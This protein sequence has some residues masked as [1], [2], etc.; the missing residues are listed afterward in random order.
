MLSTYAENIDE[1][2][3]TNKG[4][5]VIEGKWHGNVD[6][7]HE[8][9]KAVAFLTNLTIGKHKFAPQKI[10]E[11]EETVLVAIVNSAQDIAFILQEL[12]AGY[13]KNPVDEETVETLYLFPDLYKHITRRREEI[14][15]AAAAS[16]ATA[17]AKMLNKYTSEDPLIMMTADRQLFLNINFSD[18]VYIKIFH[19]HYLCR[20]TFSK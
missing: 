15:A 7:V 6:K 19:Q 9:C 8:I 14:P 5:R 12:A 3:R 13:A 1:L 18:V 10:F 2:V 4:A 16:N 17:L 11:D 20:D